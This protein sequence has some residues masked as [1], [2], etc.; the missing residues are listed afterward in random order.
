MANPTNNDQILVER[1][2][3]GDKKAFDELV[4]KHQNK[5]LNIALSLMENYEEAKDITQEAFVKA[6]ISIKTFRGQ[7]TFFTWFCRI[8]INL[9]KNRL[10]FLGR[11]AWFIPISIDKS[12]TTQE[13]EEIPSEIRDDSIPDDFFEKW[14]QEEQIRQKI[15]NS[16]KPIYRE[17]IVLHYLQ[18]LS[19]EEMAQ[20]LNLPI[21]TVK[22]RTHR[23]M[24]KLRELKA[25]FK[26]ML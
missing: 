15:T 20:I 22:N 19:Y 12:I 18:E 2:Q 24:M 21:G 3:G 17:V 25:S 13:G 10:R 1:A 26:D 5:A 6:Y 4:L 9:C 23:A 8:L 14:E 16:L 7:S 11:E